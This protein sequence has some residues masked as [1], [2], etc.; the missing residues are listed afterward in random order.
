[1]NLRNLLLVAGVGL[2]VSASA[3]AADV[4]VK[5]AGFHGQKGKAIVYLWKPGADGFPSKTEN[6]AVNKT[7][8]I[9]PTGITVTFS[10]VAPGTYA[11]TITH[12]ENENGKLDTGFMGKPK[13]GYGASN[14]PQNKITAPSFDQCKFDVAAAGKSVDI[15]MRY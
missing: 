1:M 10:D 12:D 13:E 4:T 3:F 6:A 8:E 9:T 14:N 11:V 5:A 15:T 7:V 2:I